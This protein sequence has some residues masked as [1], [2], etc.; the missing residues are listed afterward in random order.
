MPPH[1]ADG[2]SQREPYLAPVVSGA[3][4]GA[5]TW[6]ATDII[7]VHDCGERILP[8]RFRHFVCSR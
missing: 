8:S 7:R 1:F 2:D 3:K 6:G 5:T 4:L